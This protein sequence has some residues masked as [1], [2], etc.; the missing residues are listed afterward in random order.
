L[1]E[2]QMTTHTPT[3]E[4]VERY[5]RRGLAPIP[6]P[7]GSKNPNRQHWQQEN[8]TPEDIPRQWSNGQNVGLL[9]G[10]PSGWFVGVDLDTDLAVRLAGR[11]LEPTLTSGRETRPDSHW[12]YYC[13]G[14]ESKSF[15]DLDGSKRLLEL[16]STGC[17]TVVSPSTHPDGDRYK[18][19]ASGL[20]TATVEQADLLRQTRLLATAALIGKYLPPM[21]NPTTDEGGGRHDYALAIAGF[22]LRNGLNKDDT[23]AILKSAWDATAWPSES[24]RREAL[25]DLDGIVSDTVGKIADGEPFKGGRTLDEMVPRM[26]RTIG[27]YWGWQRATTEAPG[28]AGAGPTDDDVKKLGLIKLLADK[29]TS[30]NYFAR[31]AGGK[32]YRYSDGVYKTRGEI[33]IKQE[34]KRLVEEWAR[35]ALWSS[36]KS[37][38]VAE[39]ILVDAPELWEMPPKDEINVPNGI[40]DVRT[41]TLREHHPGFLSTVRIPVV[42]DPKAECP[43]WDRFIASTFPEDALQLAY[44]IP[45][46]LM[47]PERS[48]QKAI[49]L[50]GEGSNGK[51]TFLDNVGRFIGT[52]SIAGLSLQKLESDRFSASRLVGKLANIC[53]DLPSTHLTETSVFKAITGGDTINAEYKYRESFE[54]KPFCRLVFSAN[55]VPRSQDASHAFFRRWVVVPFDRTFEGGVEVPRHKLDAMLSNEGEFSGLLNRALD[56]L[57]GLRERGFTESETMREAWEEFRAMTDP[58]S[59]WL[60]RNTIES[61]DAYVS[62]DLLHTAYNDATEHAKLTRPNII[63]RQVPINGKRTWCWIGVGLKGDEPSPSPGVSYTNEHA[64]AQGAQDAQHY[65]NCLSSRDLGLFGDE[66]GEEGQCNNNIRNP[67]HPVQP[68]QGV[69]DPLAH[70]DTSKARFFRSEVEGGGDE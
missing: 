45:A 17:Q 5:M 61:P 54:F 63:E 38:E 66:K 47:L 50:I 49:L 39:Y 10:E 68:V 62:R 26:P 70:T 30:S 57:T 29:I 28:G 4:A 52:T 32:L 14:M 44:E 33:Y 42:F 2:M 18:W 11:F 15:F 69:K 34:V 59:V 9:T 23:L 48:V 19:S 58:V 51:S 3:R 60:D 37:E 67:V 36:R 27:K 41:R 8:W 64:S 40:L 7:A 35:T 13:P 56:A 24:K 65:T 25:R 1:N 16:R 6:I 21:R 20:E 31:D 43:E 55:Q 53:P 12:W 22:L 46:D